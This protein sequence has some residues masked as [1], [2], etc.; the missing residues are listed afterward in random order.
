MWC[1]RMYYIHTQSAICSCTRS[2]CFPAFA[3]VFSRTAASRSSAA[4]ASDA[5]FE[6][7]AATP[8][9]PKGFDTTRYRTRV[10]VPDTLDFIILFLKSKSRRY[11]FCYHDVLEAATFATSTRPSV[12]LYPFQPT[13][14]NLTSRFDLQISIGNLLYKWIYWGQ[15]VEF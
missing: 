5:F 4:C 15:L 11:Q 2:S 10:L 8:M 14:Q 13:M 12:R 6:E 3:S 7:E 9:G 1:T